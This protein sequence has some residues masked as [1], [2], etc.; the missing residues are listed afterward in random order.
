MKRVLASILVLLITSAIKGQDSA[1]IH[2]L[3]PNRFEQE[4]KM[5][6]DD[7]T[8]ITLKEDGLGLIREKNKFKSGNR[9]WE[10]LLLDTA[11]QLKH[12]LEI[13]IDQRKKLAAYENSPG[14]LHLV[15][16]NGEVS[17]MALDLFSIRLSDASVTRYE[18]KPELMFQLTHFIKVGENFVLGG[19]VN[20]EPAILLYN[21][22]GENI[23]VLPGFFQRQTE[24]IDLRPN[25]NQ[26]FNTVLIDRSDRINQ[27]LIFKT[28]DANGIEL[29]DDAIPIEN[30]YGIQTGISSVL[31]REDM[32]IVGTWGTRNSKQANGFFAVPVDPFSDQKIKYTAFGELTH[33]LDD[34][35]PK[36]AARIKNR[37]NESLKLNR[38]PDFTNYIMPYRLEENKSGFIVLAEAYQP[39]STLNRFPDTYPYYGGYG[40]TPYYTPFWGYYPGTYNRLYNPYNYY[41]NSVRNSDDIKSTQSV[42]AAFD[43]QGKVIWDFNLNLD[44]YRMPSL[45]QVADF[46]VDSEKIC[47]LFKKESE[48]IVKNISLDNQE[49]LETTEKIKLLNDTDEIRSE[50]KTAGVVRHW[51]GMNFYVWG[52]HTIRNNAKRDEGNRQVFYIN[53]LVCK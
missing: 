43:A 12:T 19:Y 33:Y 52:Q 23:K 15:F 45:E 20:N 18:I 42:V 17:K 32:S 44:S 11:L 24:L 38:I 34:Q 39:S 48:L 22:Q 3:Q 25:L 29:L 30:D 28:F 4:Q 8:V 49:I 26:T 10:L 37:T 27:R 1:K 13:E 51:Y 31:I 40:M 5:A 41:G 2:L 50:S 36:R 16:N 21:T 9:T 7:F 35:K 14:Y 47:F 6:D 53:K 46:S